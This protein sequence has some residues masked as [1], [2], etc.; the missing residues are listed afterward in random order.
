MFLFFHLKNTIKT[1]IKHSQTMFHTVWC[2]RPRARAR[3]SGDPAADRSRGG[4]DVEML[5]DEEAP[6]AAEED[7]AEP[8]AA[9]APPAGTLGTFPGNSCF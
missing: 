6:P 1:Q 5:E 4:V 7:A 9:P 2:A 8:P 3:S